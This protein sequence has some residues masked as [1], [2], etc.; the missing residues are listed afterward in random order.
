MPSTTICIR[1]SGA[2]AASGTAVITA[3]RSGEPLLYLCSLLIALAAR[4][5]AGWTSAG[6]ESA[7]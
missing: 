6:I 7:G 1:C 3:H 5:A 4:G 2:I